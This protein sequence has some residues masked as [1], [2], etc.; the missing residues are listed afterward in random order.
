VL[1]R[2]ITSV[3]LFI[4]S[5]LVCTGEMLKPNTE[6]D[7]TRVVYNEA[8]SL[9]RR[10][11]SDLALEKL[12]HLKETVGLNHTLSDKITVSIAEGYR[13][14][15]E[16]N[17]GLNLLY[18]LLN[19]PNITLLDKA[20]ACNRIAALY[21]EGPAF[22]SK[23]DSVIKY[24]YQCI[25][26]AEENGF[27]TEL[28]ASQ[29]ELGFVYGTI[30]NYK[31]YSKAIELLNNALENF[32][33]LELH[34]NAVNVSINLSQIYLELNDFDKA[35]QV[36][37]TAIAFCSE[38]DNKNLF[39][40][41]YY[42]KAAIFEKRGNY[43]KAYEYLSKSLYLNNSFFK[44]R[45]NT[46]IFEM[47]AKYETE[48]KEREN[49]E[50]R[51]NNEIQALKL[52]YKNN[53]ITFLS[54]GLCVAGMLLLVIFSLLQRKKIAYKKLVEKNIKV[55]ESED[56]LERNTA[57]MADCPE[58]KNKEAI[59]SDNHY[60]RE[61]DL[62]EKFE[63]LMKNE[64][65]YLSNQINIEEISAQLNTNRTYLSNA[66]KTAFAKNF[67]SYINE[68]RAKEAIRLLKSPEFDHYSVEGIGLQ[69][70]F[71]NRISFNSNFKKITGVSPSVFREYR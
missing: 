18:E 24:S 65:P 21:N 19:K 9:L 31:N 28:A 12:F 54:I 37:D 33:S 40:R 26:I 1:N 68:A 64:K 2:I 35:L 41:V 15:Q 11:K 49:M 67:N 3:F 45:L 47:A 14:R 62:A 42:L 58:L 23:Y 38:D 5:V 56:K 20:N 63:T 50:L 30:S 53:A 59:H 22:S 17:K 70:G 34:Q 29:N 4:I 6:T 7:S 16:Y 69:A 27:T 44:D 10:S 48:K 66:I 61:K 52:S 46:Q 25:E 36:I 13:Q 39:Y 55:I 51:K 60:I 8:V 43:E 32:H 71:N 57:L